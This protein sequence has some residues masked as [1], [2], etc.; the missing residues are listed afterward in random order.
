M[1]AFSTSEGKTRSW[2]KKEPFIVETISKHRWTIRL[3][4]N[5]FCGRIACSGIA[6]NSGFGSQIL[7]GRVVPHLGR[8][9][10]AYYSRCGTQSYS[11][12]RV[13]LRKDLLVH[14]TAAVYWRAKLNAKPARDAS[15]SYWATRTV[16]TIVMKAAPIKV[17]R[18]T[19]QRLKRLDDRTSFHSCRICSWS[20]H[21]FSW[22]LQY[23]QTPRLPSNICIRFAI[24]H[25]RFHACS[26]GLKLLEYGTSGQSTLVASHI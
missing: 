23:F 17:S 26:C 11:V 22:H 3:H 15:T 16:A 21:E 10:L 4:N 24:R 13:M 1:I 8:R 9:E 2:R 6:I 14:M 18:S 7:Q 12:G 5:D 19:S 20:C 25:H